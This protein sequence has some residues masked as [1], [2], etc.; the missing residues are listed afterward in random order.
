MY[1]SGVRFE[2][3]AAKAEAN[4]AKH[5]V[6]F[7]EAATVFVDQLALTRRDEGTTDEER[8]VTIGM[9][10]KGRPLVVVYCW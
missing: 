5:G 7:A 1:T 2:W 10:T 6:R 9:G 8:Y 3:D 4:V